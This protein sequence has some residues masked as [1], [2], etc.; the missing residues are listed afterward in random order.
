MDEEHMELVMD[1]KAYMDMQSI[2][3]TC[4]KV[5]TFRWEYVES[6]KKWI[7]QDLFTN[8]DDL[9]KELEN[10]NLKVNHKK[11]KYGLPPR[12]N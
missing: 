5:N 12:L 11:K 9:V 4:M 6:K 10:L 8:F 3:T 7:T 1:D 2:V